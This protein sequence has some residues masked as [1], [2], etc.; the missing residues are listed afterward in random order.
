MD[1]IDMKTFGLMAA[2]VIGVDEAHG[3]TCRASD[4]SNPVVARM[5]AAS[6][7]T[8]SVAAM[9]CTSSESRIDRNSIFGRTLPSRNG[10][11]SV[12]KTTSSLLVIVNLPVLASSHIGASSRWY[13][14][15]RSTL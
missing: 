12:S 5:R 3:V 11:M 7:Y 1:T 4:A 15:M 2:I 8:G 9:R 6:S 13:G 14:S 10:L